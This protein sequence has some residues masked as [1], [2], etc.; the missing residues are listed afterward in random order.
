MSPKAVFHNLDV[1]SPDFK[2]L[3]LQERPELVFHQ[4]AQVDVQRSIR[5]PQYDA[6]MN[7][8]G[9]INV[10]ESCCSAAV[11]KLIYA[12]SCAVYGDLAVDKISEQDSTHPISFYGVSKL[13]PELY[14]RMFHQLYD[15]NYTILRYSNVYGPRQTS[16]GEG[17]VIAI[18]VDRIKKGL[19]LVIH[20]DG[21]QTRDFIYIKDVVEA[22]YAAIQCGDNQTIHAATARR[23][24]VNELATMLKNIHGAPIEVKY[25]AERP[26]DI[27]HSCLDNQK[28]LQFLGWKPRYS[29]LSG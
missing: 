28:A 11:K 16:K 25:G 4:A 18:F 6:E 12:S 21:E 15:L 19:P 23:T 20:G 2:E 7:I 24:S 3:I 9:T 8:I 14:I 26:G 5:N 1:R 27:K 17:G 10:L 22:N 13:T 29:V